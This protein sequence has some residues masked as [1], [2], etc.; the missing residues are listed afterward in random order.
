[1]LAPDGQREAQPLIVACSMPPQ[2]LKKPGWLRH[3]Q[4]RSRYPSLEKGDDGGLP[5]LGLDGGFTADLLANADALVLDYP[6]CSGEPCPNPDF[7]ERPIS[8]S[9][10]LEITRPP[11][12]A[13]G[14]EL[15][16]LEPVA[17][18]WPTSNIEERVLVEERKG[19]KAN[20]PNALHVT[21]GKGKTLWWRTS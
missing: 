17:A 9:R 15:L 16:Q 18:L 20:Q 8:D 2:E 3:G 5:F 21:E 4:S 11:R 19:I 1:M 7:Q 14:L 10:F 12:R 6:S 13:Q